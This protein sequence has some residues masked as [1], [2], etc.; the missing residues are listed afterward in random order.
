VWRWGGRYRVNKDAMHFEVVA[1]PAELAAGIDPATVPGGDSV[2]SP[3]PNPTDPEEAEIMAAAKEILEAIE[4]SR[5][6]TVEYL[7]TVI[8]DTEARL[9][10]RLDLLEKAAPVGRERGSNKVYVVDSDGKLHVQK[11]EL[12]LL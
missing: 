9:N 5:N 10:A 1:S 4:K 3:T 2:P 8:Q 11:E 7:V 6:A 12:L